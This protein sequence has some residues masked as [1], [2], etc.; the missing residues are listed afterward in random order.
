MVSVLLRRPHW[1]YA[2]DLMSSP[3]ACLCR[4][5][6]IQ[7]VYHEHDAPGEQSLRGAVGRL[8]AFTRRRAGQV[9][10]I[11][12]I[13][14]AERARVFRE[15]LKSRETSVVW[16][17]PR[18]E[19]VRENNPGAGIK[20]LYHGSIN[21]AR[22]PLTLIGALRLLPDKVSLRIGGYETI[23]SRGYLDEFRKHAESQG[24][25]AGRIEIM[26]PV[27][28][29]NELMDLCA[30]AQIGIGFLPRL[31]GDI[32]MTAMFGAS[33][34]VFD[35][36]ACGLALIVSDQPGWAGP[37]VASGTAVACNPE[38]PSS[39]AN[40]VQSLIRNP[41]ELRQRGERGRQLILDGWNYEAQFQPLLAAL[42]KT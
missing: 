34:K 17:C 1:V 8:L 29:R 37:L 11:V 10:D 42:E 39:I 41:A 32:N 31:S 15:T 40:A 23:G 14:N 28:A 16:N 36:M 3:V 19:E 7:T 24:L 22:L 33:N 9:A 26:P 27:P 2:S 13:P 38:D 5:L 12:A 35:Y 25:E 6:G 18:R 20:L 30:G 4:M 21:A